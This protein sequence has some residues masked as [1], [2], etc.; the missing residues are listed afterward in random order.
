MEILTSKSEQSCD[1]EANHVAVL[2]LEEK[3]GRQKR[4][5]E[6]DG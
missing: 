6:T 1:Y 3:H 2:F 4:T 5:E